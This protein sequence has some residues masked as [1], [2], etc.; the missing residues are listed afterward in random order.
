MMDKKMTIEAL[1]KMLVND[2]LTVEALTNKIIQK[3]GF[4]ERDN[5]LITPN[6][7]A[8]LE[9]AKQLDAQG[10]DKDN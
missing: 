9:R 1:H 8:A 10:I 2:E 7:T 3:S 4:N 6:Y 5:F